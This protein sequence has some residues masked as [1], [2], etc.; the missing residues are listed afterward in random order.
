MRMSPISDGLNVAGRERERERER[1]KGVLQRA[2]RESSGAEHCTICPLSFASRPRDVSQGDTKLY[3]QGKSADFFFRLKTM[4]AMH[5][6]MG[7]SV[8][9]RNRQRGSWHWKLF[10]SIETALFTASDNDSYREGF[11]S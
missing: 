6:E 5:T 8:L 4:F 11:S 2:S 1:E 9:V 7:E 3:Q 10:L